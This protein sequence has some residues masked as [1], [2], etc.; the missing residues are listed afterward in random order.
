M[1]TSIAAIEVSSV[2]TELVN[3]SSGF[4][5][6]L[7]PFTTVFDGD[8]VLGNSVIV[9]VFS[10]STS[11]T[12]SGS[13]GLDF[14]SSNSNSVTT[15]KVIV[16]NT[17]KQQTDLKVTEFAKLGTYAPK[18]I[19]QMLDNINKDIIDYVYSFVTS[20]NFAGVVSA[21]WSESAPTLE[22][23]N[24]LVEKA[25]ASRKLNK[26]SIKV[27]I[28]SAGYAIIKTAYQALARDAA[29]SLDYELIPVYNSAFTRTAVT[30]GTG[31]AIGFGA[32][33]GMGEEFTFIPSA[34]DSVGYGLHVVTDLIKR[35]RSFCLICN[36]GVKVVN[37]DGLL[38]A[39]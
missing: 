35:Q 6:S 26:N 20:A 27:L 1:P 32:D 21:N 12:A 17:S 23:L 11:L 2:A 8:V 15:A 5:D 33:Q 38:F 13:A 10:T 25:K 16:E 34:D 29:G 4:G 7:K 39:A 24:T 14:S 28:P 18:M 37:A 36:Y 3:K 22:K 30:D 31:I 9:P 19:T